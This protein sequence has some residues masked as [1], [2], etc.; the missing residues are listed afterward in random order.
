MS[1]PVNTYRRYA[2]AGA[3]FSCAVSIGFLMQFSE[4][5]YAGHS[6]IDV[7]NLSKNVSADGSQISKTSLP[8]LP[9]ELDEA[10]TLPSQAVVLVVSRDAPI[11]LLPQEEISPNL[12]CEISLNAEPVAGAFVKL[13]VQAPCMAGERLTVRHS[14]MLFTDILGEDGNLSLEVPAL[15]EQ[16]L[17]VVAFANG[18]GAVARTDVSSLAFYDR[19][20]VQWSGEAGIELH[21]LEFG[22]NYG[23]AGHVWRE[24]ARDVLYVASGEGGYLTRLG[25]DAL[26]DGKFAEIYTFPSMTSEQ[27]GTI[28]LSLEAEVGASNC[29]R[30]VDA[31][32]IEVRRGKPSRVQNLYLNIPNCDA[33]GEFLVLKNLLED[34]KIARN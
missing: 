24:S 17:F 13:D 19:V 25:N 8:S 30:S 14:D 26:K 16:A 28:A 22:A 1:K 15:A 6:P 7:D 34:L 18:D 11:G 5:G 4:P 2:L 29:N 27:I 12:G 31:Q 9:K 20:A 23:E 3:T 10:A 33:A 21:A 32:S